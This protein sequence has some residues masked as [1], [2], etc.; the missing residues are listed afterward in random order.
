MIGGV[1]KTKVSVVFAREFAT[2]EN[3]MKDGRFDLVM[4]RPSD[5]PARGMRDNG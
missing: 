5:Y 2:L 1:L 3:G 4:A